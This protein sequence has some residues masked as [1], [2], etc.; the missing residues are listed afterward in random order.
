[1]EMAKC[2]AK[3]VEFN[4][5]RFGYAEEPAWLR[6]CLSDYAGVLSIEETRTKSGLRGLKMKTVWGEYTAFL[7]DYIVYKRGIRLQIYSAKAFRK[8]FKFENQQTTIFEKG[9]SNALES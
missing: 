9:G 8:M 2:T 1:M 6:D 5:Y 3:P 7:G 4:V